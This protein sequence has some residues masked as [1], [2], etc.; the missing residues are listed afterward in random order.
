M[1]RSSNWRRS[2]AISRRPM[3]PL[4]CQAPLGGGGDSDRHAEAQENLPDADTP[5]R[6]GLRLCLSSVRELALRVLKPLARPHFL[7]QRLL[8]AGQLAKAKKA[9]VVLGVANT[10][11]SLI[12]AVE[13]IQHGQS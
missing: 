9:L 11:K 4:S 13:L 6:A 12:Y 3:S 10:P 7:S 2:T 1:T 5:R 8:L